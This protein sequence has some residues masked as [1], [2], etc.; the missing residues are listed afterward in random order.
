ME[1]VSS[2]PPKKAKLT[3]PFTRLRSVRHGIAP[4]ALAAIVLGAALWGTYQFVEPAPPNRLTI[5]TGSEQGAYYRFAQQMQREF[6]SEGIELDIMT[7]AG[8]VEN[9]KKLGDD[10]G[11]QIAFVQ[12]GI[13]SAAEYPRLKGLGSMYFEPLWIFSRKGEALNDINDMAGLRI[14]VG[15][16]GSGTQQ[17]AEELLSANGLDATDLELSMESGDAAAD[18]LLNDRIDAAVTI[19][20]ANST[21]VERLLESDQVQLMNM[22]RAAAYSRRYSWFSNLSL[23]EGVVD[24]GRN[25]PD[26]NI[27]LISVAATLIARND[28]H[29]ALADL[30]MQTAGKVFKGSSLF[31]GAGE[32]PSPE[33]LDFP[34]STEAD[35]YYK[36]GIPLL[37]RYLPFWAAN[38]IDRL[39]VMALPL[40][41]LLLPLTR[42]LPPAY[43]WTVRKKVFR[44]YEEVQSIDQSAFNDPEKGNLQRCLAEL[45]RI[46]V[47][48]RDIEVP[49]GYAHELYVLR[50]HVDLMKRQITDRLAHSGDPLPSD[51]VS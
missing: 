45:D 15:P 42:I 7:T 51:V 16:R 38:L 50:Q 29:P 43:R 46:E 3:S 20:A 19:A 35:R 40:I 4:T 27:E 36:Y 14:A 47:G 5:A 24:L 37:Q 9:L 18:A 30:A 10:G 32:F 34:L 41:A 33:Y 6:A 11:A 25:I 21:L 12:S 48:A 44:W 28:L 8:S 22:S 13:G 31:S 39:K 1:S 17:V 23:P 2:Q 26:R 49:L